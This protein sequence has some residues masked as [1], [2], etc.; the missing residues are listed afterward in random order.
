MN[1][2]PNLQNRNVQ[3]SQVGEHVLED[4]VGHP[5]EVSWVEIYLDG[6]G[7]D[8]SCNELIPCYIKRQDT[9]RGYA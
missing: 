1:A 7:S 5:V 3:W 9:A 2:P 6:L 8:S 4:G